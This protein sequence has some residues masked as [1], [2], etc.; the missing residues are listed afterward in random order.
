MK[1]EGN[2]QPRGGPEWIEWDS[3]KGGYWGRGFCRAREKMWVPVTCFEGTVWRGW[4]RWGGVGWGEEGGAPSLCTLLAVLD[5]Q[6]PTYILSAYAH[7]I[8]VIMVMCPFVIGSRPPLLLCS[9]PILD[10]LFWDNL[11]S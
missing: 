10:F 3:L 5:M 1:Y 8:P 6:P 7:D 9:S 4:G 11:K 2:S